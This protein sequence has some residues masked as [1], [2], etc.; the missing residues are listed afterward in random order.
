MRLIDY[1]EFRQTNPVI[2]EEKQ[3]SEQ[4]LEDTEESENK[5]FGIGDKLF[6][7]RCL[8]SD[9]GGVL[10]SPKEP[11]DFAGHSDLFIDCREESVVDFGVERGILNESEELN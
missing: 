6:Q 1:F 3:E 10:E 11:Q 4:F 2:G 8:L 9:F 5:S 7:L